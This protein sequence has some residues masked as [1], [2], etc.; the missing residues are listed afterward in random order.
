[1]LTMHHLVSGKNHLLEGEGKEQGFSTC[2]VCPRAAGVCES[3]QRHEGE[4][5]SQPLHSA[6]ENTPSTSTPHKTAT[7][8]FKY[9]QLCSADVLF[10]I[11]KQVPSYFSCLRKFCNAVFAVRVQKCFVDYKTSPN[12]FHRH[13]VMRKIAGF[14]FLGELI[15]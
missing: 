13:E 5:P 7:K 9:D 1:M 14:S 3:P 2:A 6:S 8:M 12:V 10:P 4:N 15:P 11:L